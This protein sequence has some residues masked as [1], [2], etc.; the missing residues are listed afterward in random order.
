MISKVMVFIFV[1]TLTL[2]NGM[3]ENMIMIMYHEAYYEI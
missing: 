2:K 3:K 1:K